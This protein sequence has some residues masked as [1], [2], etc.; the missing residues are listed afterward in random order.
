MKKEY[1]ELRK[2]IKNSKTILITGHI[3]PDGDAVGSTLAMYNYI[4]KL[5]TYIDIILLKLHNTFSY[6]HN[7]DKIKTNETNLK[8]EYDLLIIFDCGD[9]KRI[10]FNIDNYIFKKI[11]VID[12]HKT[13]E[14][15]GNLTILDYKSPSTCEIVYDI[16]KSFKYDIDLQIAECL[17][18]GIL[19]DTGS[20]K[21]LNVIPSSFLVAYELIKIGVNPNRISRLA[22]DII[23]LNKLELIKYTYAN[24]EI[25]NN[26]IAYLYINKEILNK[27]DDEENIHEGL[28]NYGK[29]IEGIEVSIFIRQL[30]ENLYKVS[31]RSTDKV[32]VA[33][34]SKKYMGGGHTAAAGFEYLG[35]L[36]DIKNNLIKDIQLQL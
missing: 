7:F 2:I 3:D 16:L 13:H 28:V 23:S 6:L 9:I 22:M 35:N 10:N 17:Y 14:D 8:K 32:D 1:N 11:V 30:D 15:F 36:E 21:N 33:I 12:H 31:M 20:F 29:N 34:I 4:S 24:L 25:I 5:N 19:T 18:T 27:Y 26:N